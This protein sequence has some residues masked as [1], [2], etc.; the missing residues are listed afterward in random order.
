MVFFGCQVQ[1]ESASPSQENSSNGVPDILDIR[2]LSD[3]EVVSGA[4]R[5]DRQRML[6]DLLYEALQA[7]NEDRLLTPIDDNAHARFKRVLA[8]DSDN[9]IALQGLQDIVARYLQL[10][11]ESI[12]RGLFE[13]AKT[14]LDRAGFVDKSHPDIAGVSEA[15]RQEMK[16]EDLFFELDYPQYA[17]RTEQAREQLADIARQAREHEAFFLIIAPNDDLGRW[18]VAVMREAVTGYRLRGNIELASRTSIRL[19]MPASKD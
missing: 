13:E 12:Y 10:A 6:A 19:R 5:V 7:L 4:P 8:V 17:S 18:M 1:Q 14:M 3:A 15:L 9:E 2:V 16:S 11:E